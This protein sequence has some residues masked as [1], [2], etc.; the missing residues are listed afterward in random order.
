MKRCS[1]CL[2]LT[3]LI[4][5][6][7]S[8]PLVAQK[9]TGTISGVVSDPTGAVVPQATVIITNKDTGLIRTVTSNEMGEYVAPDLPNGIYHITVKQAAFKEA[10]INNVELHVASTALVNVQLQLGNTSEE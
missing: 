6:F 1:S 9:I 3:A 8:T 4:L 7:I 5:L 2:F 10:V